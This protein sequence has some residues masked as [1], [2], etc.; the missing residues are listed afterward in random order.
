MKPVTQK[1]TPIRNILLVTAMGL[2][3]YAIPH[4]TGAKP[5]LDSA[6]RAASKAA[7]VKESARA[8]APISKSRI[9]T[10]AAPLV[11]T[12]NGVLGIAPAG[13]A[14]GTLTSRLSRPGTAGATCAV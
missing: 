7:L 1:T 3:A 4:A 12:I 9:Q 13:G 6:K 2:I 8:D 10:P 5:S 11:C 14:T